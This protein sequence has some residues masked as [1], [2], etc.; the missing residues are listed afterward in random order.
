MVATEGLTWWP[1]GCGGSSLVTVSAAMAAFLVGVG[2][3]RKMINRR[4]FG[5]GN[6]TC[7]NDLK[8]AVTNGSDTKRMKVEA[9]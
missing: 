7:A 2:E 9:Q 3:R 8:V 6:L 5:G 1:F 4:E